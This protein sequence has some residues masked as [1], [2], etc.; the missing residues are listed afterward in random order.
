MDL[1]VVDW[2][3]IS[4]I[5]AAVIASLVALYISDQWRYQKGTEVIANEA[6]RL[7]AELAELR[8]LIK[9]INSGTLRGEDLEQAIKSFDYQKNTVSVIMDFLGKEITDKRKNSLID[10]KADLDSLYQKLRNYAHKD[11]SQT[12]SHFM[13]LDKQGDTSIFDDVHGSIDRSESLLREL[14]LYKSR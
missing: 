7:L 13:S 11:K 4:T 6:K 2:G 14:A 9:K 5:A 12:F 8:L 10:M 3:A 1:C